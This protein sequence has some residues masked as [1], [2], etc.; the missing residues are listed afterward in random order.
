MSLG[1]WI[2]NESMSLSNE[3]LLALFYE[4]DEIVGFRVHSS[5][6]R[7]MRGP[8]GDSCSVWVFPEREKKNKSLLVTGDC[9]QDIGIQSAESMAQKVIEVSRRLSQIVPTDIVP[10]ERYDWVDGKWVREG[11]EKLPPMTAEELAKIRDI[12]SKPFPSEEN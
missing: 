2:S 11:A 5:V 6:H 1:A 9:M 3:R 7:A 10:T 4:P 12:L 8:G